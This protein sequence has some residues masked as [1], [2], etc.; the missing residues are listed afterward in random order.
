M[1]ISFIHKSHNTDELTDELKSSAI[2]HSQS[3]LSSKFE[4]ELI[5]KAVNIG[6]EAD[7]TISSVSIFA[8]LSEVFPDTICLLTRVLCS[9]MLCCLSTF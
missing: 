9:D 5:P 6:D 8:F 1:S 7:L 3:V 2:M 4:M